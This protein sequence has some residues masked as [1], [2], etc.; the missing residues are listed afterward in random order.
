MAGLGL[1]GL[2]ITQTRGAVSGQ[3]RNTRCRRRERRAYR[4]TSKSELD[5]P[6]SRRNRLEAARTS[7]PAQKRRSRFCPSTVR[8]AVT[9]NVCQCLHD[10]PPHSNAHGNRVDAR[11]QQ[12]IRPAQIRCSARPIRARLACFGKSIFALP[13]PTP[14]CR[15]HGR[16]A[17]AQHLSGVRLGGAL[18]WYPQAGDSERWARSTEGPKFRQPAPIVARSRLSASIGVAGTFSRPHQRLGSFSGG[19][20]GSASGAGLARGRGRL[21]VGP[22]CRFGLRWRLDPNL[23]GRGLRQ[24]TSRSPGRT[25]ILH[26]PSESVQRKC[27]MRFGVNLLILIC[28][29]FFTPTP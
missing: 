3:D 27:S 10:A 1:T 11:A 8:F 13:F 21:H 2:G 25:R 4:F 19:L 22:I 24:P 28:L 16:S 18:D 15:P 23:G 6:W 9:L 7:F 20:P 17:A 5:A 29:S 12:R 14:P 26:L